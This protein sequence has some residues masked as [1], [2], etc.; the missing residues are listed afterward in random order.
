MNF[1]LDT[2]AKREYPIIAHFLGGQEIIW[3]IVEIGAKV[4]VSKNPQLS[5]ARAREIEAGIIWGAYARESMRLE[6]KTQTEW[7]TISDDY[8]QLYDQMICAEETQ[9][10]QAMLVELT[11]TRTLLQDMV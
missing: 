6:E 1:N 3:G 4:E 5:M 11:G 8:F 10:I 2:N 9:T 7:R